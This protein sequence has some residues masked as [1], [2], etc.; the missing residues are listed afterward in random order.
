MRFLR[1]NE[2]PPRSS[3]SRRFNS[4]SE[5]AATCPSGWTV[6]TLRDDPLSLRGAELPQR[7]ARTPRRKPSGFNL[8]SFVSFVVGLSAIECAAGRAV[9]GKVL[10]PRLFDFMTVL[11]SVRLP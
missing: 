9:E 4:G 10:D 7:T 11:R 5:A 3:R 1:R 6:H 2:A 8:V